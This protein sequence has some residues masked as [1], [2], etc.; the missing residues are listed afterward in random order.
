M[1]NFVTEILSGI[2]GAGLVSLSVLIFRQLMAWYRF[3][4][5][6]QVWRPF[7]T[8]PSIIVITG[9]Q[10]GHTIKVSVNETRSAENIQKL[11]G[12]RNSLSLAVSSHDSVS[13]EGK[14]V[15]AL[16]SAP[17]N[18]V[19]RT[20][21]QSL[22][23][24]LNYAYTADKDLI[25]NGELFR[26]EYRNNI[27]IRDYALVCKATNP[28]SPNHKFLV[29]S[30]NHGIGTQG[31]VLAVTSA[32]E[33][34][35][36]ANAIGKTDF[37]A[38]IETTCDTRFQE[39]PTNIAVIRCNIL[40][41]MSQAPIRTVSETRQERL[42]VLIKEI[43]GDDKYLDHVRAVTELAVRISNTIQSKGIDID[44]D[45][46][47]FGSMLHDIGRTKSDGIDHGLIG[48]EI[49]QQ[50]RARFIKDFSLMPDTIEKISEA[51]KCHIVGGISGEWVKSAK[52]RIP[53]G[54]YTPRSLEAKIVALSDQLLHNRHKDYSVLKEA[55][56]LDI[57]VFKHI[58]GLTSE[59][60]RIAFGVT[61]E[62]NKK[63]DL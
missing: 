30:G 2:V 44:I 26:S 11:L 14:N 48:S 25:V 31:G 42:L 52:L 38:I 45:A 51:I 63:N 9:K 16:G 27:L 40:T 19:T 50:R 39:S 36:I 13:L 12:G 23:G 10:E 22:Q 4:P 32:V 33:I 57:E 41:A 6:H 20:L 34:S 60:V 58:F 53:K 15:I 46:V 61:A 59:I 24:Q 54:D 49:F 55:P 43:G 1:S 5:F 8:G 7:A 3:R 56:A 29:F 18:E 47:Y 35:E 28:F 17:A 21:L 62:V 37:Y